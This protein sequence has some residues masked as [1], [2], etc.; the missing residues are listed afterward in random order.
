MVL[1]E[2]KQFKPEMVKRKMFFCIATYSIKYKQLGKFQAKE[3]G[4]A[5]WEFDFCKAG[6][7]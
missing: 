3:R 6:W 2:D 5:I 1:L 7:E 4:R